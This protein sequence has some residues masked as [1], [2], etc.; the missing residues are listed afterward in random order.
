MKVLV[1]GGCGFIGSHVIDALI[2][3]EHEIIV[4]DNCSTGRLENSFI[5]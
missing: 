4:I 5:K 1:T 2:A 3:D